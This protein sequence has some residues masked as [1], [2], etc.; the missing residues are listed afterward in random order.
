MMTYTYLQK[1]KLGKNT[2]TI[3]YISREDIQNIPNMCTA[4]KLACA[5]EL[6]RYL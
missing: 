6:V 5:F 4:T 3:I 1:N 2:G